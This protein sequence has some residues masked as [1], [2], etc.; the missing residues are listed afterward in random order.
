MTFIVP[1]VVKCQIFR[2]MKTILIYELLSVFNKI[3]C[4]YYYEGNK[5]KWD[6]VYILYRIQSLEQVLNFFF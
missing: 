3:L 6:M 1:P 4:L 2:I 5:T